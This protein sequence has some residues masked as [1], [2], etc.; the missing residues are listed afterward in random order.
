M[1]SVHA[2]ESLGSYNRIGVLLRQQDPG[3]QGQISDMKE[4]CTFGSIIT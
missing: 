2:D 3:S 1:S 4:L